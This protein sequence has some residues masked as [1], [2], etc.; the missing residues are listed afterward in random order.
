MRDIIILPPNF[1]IGPHTAQ[2]FLERIIKK[3]SYTSEDE[4]VAIEVVRNILTSRVL[5]QQKLGGG[6]VQLKYR[7]AI[8]IYNTDAEFIITTYSDDNVKDKVEWIYKFPPLMRFKGTID[9]KC[10]I[11]LIT[12]GFIPIRKDGRFI[13][14]QIDQ[15]LFEYDPK[16]NIICPL[17]IEK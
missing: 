9:S 15:Q 3:E 2:R 11:E 6:K 12:K 13:V 17:V 8:F 4:G 5:K 7:N 14:G 16:Y 10:K 1:G